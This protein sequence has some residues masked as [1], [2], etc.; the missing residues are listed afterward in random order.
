MY[1]E[2]KASSSVFHYSRSKSRFVLRKTQTSGEI[3]PVDGVHTTFFFLDRIILYLKNMRII[4]YVYVECIIIYKSL[5]KDMLD[6]AQKIS[7]PFGSN[8][9]TSF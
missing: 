8:Y 4:V 6:C 2:K 3:K 9:F 5:L 7:T 1:Q